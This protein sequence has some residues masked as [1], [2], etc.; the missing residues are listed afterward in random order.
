MPLEAV[1]QKGDIA[2]PNL[3]EVSVEGILEISGIKHTVELIKGDAE[4]TRMERVLGVVKKVIENPVV[5]KLVKGAANYVIDKVE[6]KGII[7]AAEVC[8]DY[9]LPGEVPLVKIAIM[10]ITGLAGF[11][12]A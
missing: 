8:G 6:V 12:K 5:Q 11:L 3:P 1:S 10:V 2:T 7:K 4:Q 9:L